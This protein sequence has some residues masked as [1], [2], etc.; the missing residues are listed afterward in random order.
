MEYRST[1]QLADFESWMIW[2]FTIFT[3]TL[4]FLS[5]LM[6]SS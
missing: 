4:Q 6:I 1:E 2:K 5:Y 3:E